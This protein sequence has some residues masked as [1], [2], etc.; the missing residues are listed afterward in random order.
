MPPS[1][2]SETHDSLDH[3]WQMMEIKLASS[4]DHPCTLR[5]LGWIRNP[6]QMITELCCGDLKTFYKNKIET[7]QYSESHALRLLKETASGLLYLHAVGIVHRDIKPGN[8]LVGLKDVT[9][10]IA[11]YGISRVADTS[12]TMTQTGT[13][14]YMAPEVTRGERYGFAADV[15]SF[16]IMMYELCDRDLPYSKHERDRPM[17]LAVDVSEGRRPDIREEWNP[18]ILYIL[19]ACWSGD[20]ARRLPL[21]KVA[22]LIA[23]IM[24]TKSTSPP[25][26]ITLPGVSQL[27]PGERWRC[28]K[29]DSR[30]VP[31]GEILGSGSYSTVY[32]TVFQGKDAAF[33]LF[34]NAT[35]EKAFK[36]I[37]I[38]FSL[39]HP[40]IIG[41]YAW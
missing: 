34:R 24:T 2:Q 1:A 32:S 37:E 27:A 38:T 31:L 28:V 12:Q 9:A 11:D 21:G 40:N 7:L 20:P 35:E 33:K 39:R 4:L 14:L 3:F 10:K 19:S 26:M 18:A 30:N 22:S 17:R 36:E 25:G 41:M 16:A 29:T 5:L 23:T 6:P 8:I 13:V 15:F